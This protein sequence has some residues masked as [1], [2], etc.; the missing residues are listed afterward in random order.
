MLTLGFRLLIIGLML[1]LGQCEHQTLDLLISWL[2]SNNTHTDHWPR[3]LHVCKTLFIMIHLSKISASE[4]CR[5]HSS[6]II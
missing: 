6:D 4:K 1:A 5:G 2:K 3:D